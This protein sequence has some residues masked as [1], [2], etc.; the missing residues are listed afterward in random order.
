MYDLTIPIEN[1]TRYTIEEIKFQFRIYENE[2]LIFSKNITVG[3]YLQHRF[4]SKLEPGEKEI[5]ELNDIDEVYIGS[6]VKN[7]K[8]T[9]DVKLLEVNPKPLED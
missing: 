5:I 7:N 2:K 3:E 4:D 1:N 6:G 8:W 9:Y